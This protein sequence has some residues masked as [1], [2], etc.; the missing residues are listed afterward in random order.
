MK[1]TDE[2]VVAH[3]KAH[4]HLGMV[5]KEYGDQM[6]VFECGSVSR[7][8]MIRAC[9]LFEEGQRAKTPAE[10]LQP[11][12]D[13]S[14]PTGYRYFGPDIAGDGRPD[15]LCWIMHAIGGSLDADHEVGV[16]RRLLAP[17]L[18]TGRRSLG[19]VWPSGELPLRGV[20][21]RFDPL[22]PWIVERI[23]DGNEMGRD[24]PPGVDAPQDLSYALSF[25]LAGEVPTR[26]T[27]GHI[28]EGEIGYL[29]TVARAET[30][31]ANRELIRPGSPLSGGQQVVC[32][33]DG[34]QVVRL[35]DRRSFT[36]E[37]LS[38]DH[39][40]REH[41]HY[42][43]DA[44]RGDI[45]LLSYRDPDGVP[46]VTVEIDVAGDEPCVV[47]FQGPRNGDVEDRLCRARMAWL[48]TDHIGVW[49]DSIADLW[50]ERMGLV[51]PLAAYRS[52][53]P[54][55]RVEFSAERLQQSASSL[56]RLSP[57]DLLLEPVG[58]ASSRARLAVSDFVLD[59]S[60]CVDLHISDVRHASGGLREV[61]VW[62][63]DPPRASLRHG[64]RWASALAPMKPST[65]LVW[66]LQ[67]DG[68][69]ERPAFWCIG[70]TGSVHVD[71]DPL[72]ALTAAGISIKP[73]ESD[74]VL[75]SG[76]LA[77]AAKDARLHPDCGKASW[78]LDGGVMRRAF[79]GY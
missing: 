9:L 79:L 26:I 37:G 34:A 21:T 64:G 16:L 5:F 58:G 18:V 73:P 2:Q 3:V 15:L 69:D 48:I 72:K 43:D 57:L 45:V 46:L 67:A 60:S 51:A 28:D 59:L 63:C 36:E 62:R 52:L 77:Q 68:E 70:D 71:A 32:W 47:Q 75:D 6:V 38:M 76:E 78:I 30:S 42:F 74:A 39:C 8:E 4:G 13:D 22:V 1:W 61:L 56:S 33:P 14:S 49:R 20:F 66:G 7:I 23:R 10:V 65:V 54:A 27:L 11:H 24:L 19:H 55:S 53:N 41:L 44:L 31:P 17:A 29:S 12:L 35:L 25:F 50:L 40:L